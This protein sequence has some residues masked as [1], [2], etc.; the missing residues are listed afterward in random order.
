MPASRFRGPSCPTAADDRTSPAGETAPM[1]AAERIEHDEPDVIP[2]PA[3]WQPPADTR[4]E[5]PGVDRSTPPRR[6][7][8]P[9]PKNKTFWKETLDPQTAAESSWI[10]QEFADASIP[11]E[12]LEAAR[13]NLTVRDYFVD[14]HLP[15][16]MQKKRSAG[17]I[18]KYFQVL[19]WWER[20]APRREATATEQWSG[21]A[22]GSITS[23]YLQAAIDAMRQKLS[24]GSVRPAVSHLKG[25]LNHA[26][27]MGVVQ[28]SLAVVSPREPSHVRRTYTDEEIARIYAALA[29]F[30]ELQ[31]GFVL[32]ICLGLRPSD[33]FALHKFNFDLDGDRP[34]MWVDT[35]K[36]NKT[37]R[38]PLVPVVVL[39]LRRLLSLASGDHLFTKWI[40]L[41]T[42][43]P[44]R[45]NAVNRRQ[46]VLRMI[47]AELGICEKKCWQIA[48][49]TCN[50]RFDMPGFP[51][52]GAL[53]LGHVK[54]SVNEVS[55]SD[56]KEIMWRAAHARQYPP[57]FFDFQ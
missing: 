4:T 11:P 36:T 34:F 28:R 20:F 40:S 7:R 35:V 6:K 16:L 19:N 46:A 54:Q 25:I 17:T 26:R 44:N 8:R 55:Y 21:P 32:A 39:H 49:A 29:P 47:F 10:E 56:H 22:I 2:F 1:S 14:Y 27:K 42:K 9:D 31:S 5:R 33:L 23:S 3:I 48:R 50:T 13:R 12:R 15:E 53:F 30:P 43:R 57:C 52:V 38:W 18:E 41:K 24:D 51:G 45:G 37:W